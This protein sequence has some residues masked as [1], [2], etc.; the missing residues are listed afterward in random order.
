[1]KRGDV[2]EFPAVF[3]RELHMANPVRSITAPVG[4]RNG[5]TVMP[6]RPPDV[7]VITD[8]FDRIHVANGG[9]AEIGGLWATDRAMLIAEVTAQIIVFQT[10]NKR[11]VI[12]GVVDPG[13]GTL[14]LMNQ[15]AASPSPTPAG[16]IT[17][18]V[19]PAPGN[20]PEQ[21]G[22]VGIFVADVSTMPGLGTID[23]TVVNSSYVRRLV[24]VDGSSINWFGVVLPLSGAQTLGTIPHINFTPTP[25]QGGYQDATYDSFGGWGQLWADYTSVIGGQMAASGADQ[26]LVIPFYRTSQQRNLGDFLLNWREVVAAVVTAAIIDVDPLR[27]RDKFTFD[28]IVSSSF[29]NGWVAHLEFNTKAVGAGAATDVL[30]D[31]DGVAGGSNWRPPNGVI[32]LNRQSPSPNPVGGRHWYVG[33][34]WG[35]KF[36]ALY[37]GNLNG[38][39]ASRNHLL[40]HG[41]WMYCT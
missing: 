18:T 24:R 26:V 14:K 16:G 2:S 39:A 5:Q 4:T 21:V 11:P 22:P 31:L 36:A 10:A 27:L 33:G 30:F 6:N 35:S 38:H 17:A 29:S 1:V 25:I 12:D 15:L 7:A 34:R 8:L 41:L 13:G 9:T 32:Y 3:E 28:R 19:V 20:W 37:G 40:Y 23:P